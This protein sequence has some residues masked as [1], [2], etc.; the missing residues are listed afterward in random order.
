MEKNIDFQL[1]T[2]SVQI[3][4]AITPRTICTDPSTRKSDGRFSFRDIQY[5]FFALSARTIA[6]LYVIYLGQV[7]P[8]NGEETVTTITQYSVLYAMTVH[9][10]PY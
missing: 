5:N 1:L 8:I 10:F 2:F 9:T 3:C 7:G 6:C 4:F